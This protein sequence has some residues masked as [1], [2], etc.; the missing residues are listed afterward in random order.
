MAEAPLD[1]SNF[2]I[3][4]DSLYDTSGVEYASRKSGRYPVHVRGWKCLTFGDLFDEFAAAFQFPSYFGYNRDA[5][6]DCLQDF[7]DE[8]LRYQAATSGLDLIIWHADEVLRDGSGL[9]GRV[10]LEVFIDIL[11]SAISEIRSPEGIRAGFEPVSRS[12]N[13]YLQFDDD[14]AA[15]DLAR[16]ASVGLRFSKLDR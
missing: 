7:F 15:S 11:C 16:W 8:D 10:D 9:Q 13:I 1:G 5:L 3:L 12:V 6:L 14:D 4:V 2:S